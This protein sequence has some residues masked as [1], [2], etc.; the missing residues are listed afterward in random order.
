MK[1][2]DAIDPGELNGFIGQCLIVDRPGVA[3]KRI[4]GARCIG[5]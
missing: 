2:R 5:H 4:G 1:W 3:I